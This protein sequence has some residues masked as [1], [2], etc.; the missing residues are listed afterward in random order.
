VWTIFHKLNNLR[1]IVEGAHLRI[2]A[3]NHFGA[4]PLRLTGLRV[5]RLPPFIFLF[6][7][8]GVVGTFVSCQADQFKFEK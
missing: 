1:C 7:L 5:P 6:G 2:A 3:F 4:V 8:S